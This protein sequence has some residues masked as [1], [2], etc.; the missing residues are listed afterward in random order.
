MK[1]NRI[2]W[3]L[4]RYTNM[5][6]RDCLSLLQIDN[7]NEIKSYTILSSCTSML[8]AESHTANFGSAG[9]PDR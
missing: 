6:S 7:K 2:Q 9:S 8:I 4:L 1:W 5:F 3:E